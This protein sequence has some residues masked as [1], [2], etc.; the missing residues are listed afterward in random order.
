VAVLLAETDRLA[1][2]VAGLHARARE[3][4]GAGRSVLLELEAGT[5]R[6]HPTSAAGLD[7]WSTGT[8]L[9]GPADAALVA[10]VLAGGRPLQVSPL[11]L[12]SPELRRRL[13]TPAAILAPVVSAGV[14]LGLLVLGVPAALPA[15]EWAGTIVECAAGFA[16]A[17][18]RARLQRDA[19]LQR[20][21]DDL[22]VALG[23]S[24]S[25]GFPDERL[26][27]FC[28]DIARLFAADRA[29]LWRHDRR[30]RRLDLAAASDERLPTR[31]A[32][33][34]TA[35][36]T[37]V[38]AMA[39]RHARAGLVSPGRADGAGTG[40]AA[41]VPLRGRRRA[42]GA[43]VL[44]G[45]RISP[46]DEARVLAR[47]D[48]VSR[49]LANLLENAQLIDE[50]L[51]ATRELEN[52]FDSMQDL[53]LV[54]DRA[55]R[56]T[57]ANDAAARRFGRPRAL[58]ESCSVTDLVGEALGTWLTDLAAAGGA[59]PTQTAELADPLMGGVFRVTAAPLRNAGGEP[60]GSL[61]VA[62]DVSEERR[63]E[64][65]RTALR[66]QL[67]QSQAMAHLVAGIAHE[68]NNPLQAVLGHAEL[69]RHTETLPP[70]I[71][72]SLRQVYRESDRAARI[73]RNLLFLAGSGHIVRRSVSVNAAVRRAIA[74]RAGACRRA[75][76]AID[77]HLADSLPRIS[78]DGLLLQ[79]A[80][81]N[82]ILNA[83]QALGAGGG[84]IVVRTG[85]SSSRRLISVTVRDSGPGIPASVLPRI[86]DPFFTTRDAGSGLGLPLVRRIIREHGGDVD[87][88]NHRG[89]GAVFTVHLPSPSV[90]Q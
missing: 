6:L 21:L 31:P 78:G 25:P 1:D 46:G 83:E 23:R 18:E 9:A 42:L 69:L 27:G 72:A 36:A 47:L 66:E 79:Q 26:A 62:H 16:V 35:D 71:S 70:R 3:G 64:S 30:E 28:G 81:H 49:Q 58:V 68:L 38:V 5:D 74:L 17:L 19:A 15:L 11:A 86:F 57:R 67:A 14:P 85:Y 22:M 34:S 44:D 41:V 50:V 39:L 12:T 29:A 40:V 75:G 73:V 33:I 56:V 59:Q 77:R 2:I 89:G 53:V 10:A 43:L 45:V 24:G 88:A 8:W 90:I 63:L 65:D 80:V 52:A 60:A 54:C 20:D 76:I 84:R 87:A 55:G 32:S 61:L 82:I 7:G 48:G 4:A 13:G 37:S 51:R